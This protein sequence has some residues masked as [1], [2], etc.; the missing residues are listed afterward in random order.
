MMEKAQIEAIIRSASVCRLGLLDGDT[1]Y[2][3]PLCFGY[4]NDTLYFHTSPKSR[5]L[6]LIRRH[7]RVCFEMDIPGDM[8]PAQA[9]C[10]WNMHYRSVIGFGTA[11]VLEDREAKRSALT[12]IMDQYTKGPYAFPEGKLG[13]TAVIEVVVQRMT[14]RQSKVGSPPA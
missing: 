14:G 13:I 2:V 3:V 11:S 1:P 7:P 4:R 10:D 8:V 9:P 5:K 12:V 6:D